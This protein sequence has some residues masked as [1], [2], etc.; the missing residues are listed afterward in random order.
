[1]TTGKWRE[2]R[3]AVAKNKTS[4]KKMRIIRVIVKM[5]PKATLKIIPILKLCTGTIILTEDH[6]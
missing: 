3:A 4:L 6:S 2:I 1:M 5:V